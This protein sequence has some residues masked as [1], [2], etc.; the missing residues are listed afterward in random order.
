MTTLATAADRLN[1]ALDELTSDQR[2]DAVHIMLGYLW[3]D[4][5]PETRARA[6]DAMRRHV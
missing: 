6:L 1:T 4:A 3:A 5:T 2:R